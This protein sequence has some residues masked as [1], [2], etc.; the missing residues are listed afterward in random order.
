MKLT[1]EVDDDGL[2][3]LASA[4]AAKLPA[5]IASDEALTEKA[6]EDDDLAGTPEVEE[7]K[8]TLE[9]V[10]DAIRAAVTP[11]KKSTKDQNKEEVKKILKKFGAEKGTDLDKAKYGD[12]VKALEKFTTGKK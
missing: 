4:I 9:Q 7:T 2:E 6:E 10:Q 1:I 11:G 3:A 8:A 12:V 5:P